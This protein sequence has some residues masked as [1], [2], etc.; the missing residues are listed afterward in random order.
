MNYRNNNDEC[1]GAPVIKMNT[2]DKTEFLCNIFHGIQDAIIIHDL[3]G[4]I[5]SYNMK[6]LSMLGIGMGTLEKAES[7]RNF[8]PDDINFEVFDRYFKEALDGQ[9]R[10]FTWQLKRQSDGEIIDV[11]V[12][13]TKINRSDESV[14][15]ACVRDITDKK[16]IE[17]EL[18]NSEKRYR[19][20][21]EYS[22][23]GIVIHRDGVIKY[24]NPAGARILGGMEE[25]VLGHTVLSFFPEEDREDI[26]ARLK[27]LYD[28]N[29]SMPIMEGRMVRL[30]ERIIFVEFAA[31]P[32][33]LEGRT[34]VQVVIRDITQKKIQEEYI[35]HMAL[36][37]TL[38]GLPNRDLLTDRLRQSLE[39]R[40][41]DD[42]LSAVLYI[43]LDGF[44]PINDTLGHSAGDVALKKIADRLR[45]SIRK[46]DTA[47]R[48]GG[49]EF[50]ILLDNVSNKEEI[51]DVAKRVLENINEKLVIGPASFHV[52]ASI[53]ISI[54]PYNTADA[55]KMMVLADRAM[56]KVKESGKNRYM[57]C[58]ECEN[59]QNI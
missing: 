35:K 53:G 24:I 2:E 34:A 29:I 12:F 47:A 16:K 21:V 52:G 58:Q 57:F 14:V 23:D 15:L 3:S 33:I 46:Y 25:D 44:K 32:F 48:I 1:K 11:E 36:H 40:K 18:I 27:K 6:A 45:E 43:D 13:L 28:E 41:R 31:I 59:E 22:P 50:V 37:D 54:F 56:Y 26:Q 42:K 30:D 5:Q 38:T 55:E 4:R 49:D 19:Q 7:I 20:L 39:R 51:E 8:S 17:T 10:T 9:D